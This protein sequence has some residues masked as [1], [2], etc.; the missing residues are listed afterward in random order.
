[1]NIPISRIDGAIRPSHQSLR[2]TVHVTSD[3][4]TIKD[5]KYGDDL[6]HGT[7]QHGVKVKAVGAEQRPQ[8]VRDHLHVTMHPSMFSYWAVLLP[9][10]P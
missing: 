6:P 2:D 4:A 3:R 5:P 10:Q 8:P 7:V 9:E 1:M